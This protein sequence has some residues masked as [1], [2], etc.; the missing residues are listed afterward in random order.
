M[1]QIWDASTMG[2]QQVKYY[3]Q[4]LTHQKENWILET[5]T[6][7][8]MLSMWKQRSQLPLG[9][10]VKEMLT[11][12][13]VGGSWQLTYP[14]GIPLYWLS[15]LIQ[16][17][18]WMLKNPHKLDMYICKW[19]AN[20]DV[21]L[22]LWPSRSVVSPFAHFLVSPT[23]QIKQHRLTLWGHHGSHLYP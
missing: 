4:L 12:I 1:K 2:I 21:S 3:M 9:K 11:D 19:K 10:K 6:L 23:L 8:S 5:Y 18:Q 13:D 15:V 20:S 7:Y 17:R 16:E 14:T 22:A